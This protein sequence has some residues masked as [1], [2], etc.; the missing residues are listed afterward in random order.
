[1]FDLTGN[2]TSEDIESR[3]EEPTPV[4][5]YA[6]RYTTLKFAESGVFKAAEMS[7]RSKTSSR[8]V[9]ARQSQTQP[10]INHS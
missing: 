2:S 9:A 10:L 4:P 5:R 6:L 7:A 3:P 1:L 8:E